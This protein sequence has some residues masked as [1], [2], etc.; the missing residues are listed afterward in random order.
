VPRDVSPTNTQSPV[1]SG[2]SLD[3]WTQ[4]LSSPD[5]DLALTGLVTDFCR[6]AGASAAVLLHSESTYHSERTWSFRAPDCSASLEGLTESARKASGLEPSA[7]Q[8]SDPGT[9]AGWATSLQ[10][11]GVSV[12]GLALWAGVAG[13]SASAQQIRAWLPLLAG[14][15]TVR[16]EL[17]RLRSQVSQYER[18]FRTLDRQVRVLDLERQKLAAVLNNAEIGFLVLDGQMGVTW[19]NPAMALRLNAAASGFGILRQSCHEAVC[20]SKEPC[21]SCPARAAQTSGEA[22]RA[23][24]AS[25]CGSQRRRLYA[26]AVPI[27]SSSGQ[28]HETLLMVQ[29]LSR[30]D[31]LQKSEARYR[32]LFESSL[33]AIFMSAPPDYRVVMA[34]PSTYSLLG[35]GAQELQNLTLA[36]M[37][38]PG[39]WPRMSE[40]YARVLE[41]QSLP[42]E[43]CR[44]RDA[45]GQHLD[46]TVSAL[47]FELDGQ[48]LIMCNLRDITARKRAEEELEQS[49]SLL[50]GTL[51]ST[52]DGILV[53]DSAGRITSYN[54]K[55]IQMWN[56]PP[57]VV[58]NG[59]DNQALAWVLPQLAH[60]ELFLD[61]VKEL[62]TQR[63]AESYDLIEFKDG[64]VFER[65]SQPHRM[66]SEEV[67]RVWSFR[68]VTERKKSEAKLEYR[69]QFENLIS[70][71]STHFINLATRDIDLGIQEALA[72]VGEFARA[73]RS[74]IFLF[75]DGGQ[76]ISNAYEWCAPGIPA[77]RERIQNAP[78]SSLPW[79]VDRIRKGETVHVSCLD[80]LP[81]EAAAEREVFAAQQIQ[82]LIAV[83]IV[84]GKS[85]WGF[86][87][88]HSVRW[89]KEWVSDVASLLHIA[90]ELFANALARRRAEADK[91]NLEEQL[92][93]SQKLEAVGTLAGGIAHDFNN[94]LTGILGYADML[95]AGGLS[96]SQTEKA[97]SVIERAARRA[98]ELTQQLLGFARKGKYQNIPVDLHATIAEVS[99]L[100]GRTLEKNI[101]IESSLRATDPF[102]LGD[103][104]QIQ[105]V[106][107]NLSVN[108]RDAMAGGGKLSFLTDRVTLPLRADHDSDSAAGDFIKLVVADTGCGIPLEVQPR[109]FEPFFTT[110]EQGKGTGMGL[111]MVYGIVK[112]HGGSICV[113]SDASSGTRF[114][115]LWPAVDRPS[116]VAVDAEETV[117]VRVANTVLFVDDE[118]LVR[119]VAASMLE[120]LGYKV[121]LARD[122]QEAVDVFRAR[123]DE[124]DLVI[125]DMAMPRM[126]GRECFLELRKIR[127]DV[128]A[129]LS[130]GYALDEATQR[131]LDEGM[132]GFT[133]KPYVMDHLAT[134]LI[135]AM[136]A[137]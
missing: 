28:V 126:G 117:R 74:H 60:P 20:G 89:R 120:T 1:P 34:N 112:N 95:R 91:A 86:L 125:L 104:V 90:A 114:E 115:I 82:S 39:D 99:S 56:I 3:Q 32:L 119:T 4:A 6:S 41:G 108:A 7:P 88:F 52:A 101:T 127:P 93:Q 73:D 123:Q 132:V 45:R 55:F 116:L 70:T 12:G 135:K 19:A 79:F 80:A 9:P 92:R 57:D 5:A 76:R 105:Q 100:L 17:G 94:L 40:R 24:I 14:A 103:P 136:E 16:G 69:V 54:Q 42:S 106:I 121:I 36:D 102:V 29:D 81:P 35:Y 58:M 44:I 113:S 129:I 8:T 64:R 97:A 134:A 84:Y 25:V 2:P 21:P 72:A 50:R 13:T 23:E 131:V 98:A 110:K 31:A 96:P 47:P 48:T 75:S 124:I 128:R 43:D 130:T 67:G 18:G 15:L 71:L 107:L 77:E 78:A 83:P 10:A 53:V 37:H 68:D 137:R 27:K 87:G 65:Y 118:E 61:K 109:I 62:Y 66:A 133:Q 26:T 85:T 22:T 59:D 38:L 11:G 46:C 51:E 30:L 63:E 33:D 49:F 122:G 111:S